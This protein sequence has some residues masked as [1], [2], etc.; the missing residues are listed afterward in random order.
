MSITEIIIIVSH[1]PIVI[2]AAYALVLYKKLEPELKLFSYFLFFSFVIQITALVLALNKIN[3][4]PL[5][6]IYVA[7]GFLLIVLFYMNVMNDFI[8][9]SIVAGTAMLFLVY[10]IINSF[11]FEPFFTFNS[12]A[13]TVE[14]VL[15]VILSLSTFIVL[16]NNI[17]RKRRSHVIKSLSWIN[18]G[19]FIYYAS[20]LIIFFLIRNFPI[21]LNQYTW[22]FH[23]FF[24]VVMYSCFI[25]G[26]S[27]QTRN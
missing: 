5:L 8:N 14:S 3:N 17:V 16:L 19:L 18:S 20:N 23:S 6:H 4:L 11:F 22:I 10:T 2:S 21:V 1:I 15:V 7:A 27:K 25:I 26:F 13:L 12:N 9:P 24:S